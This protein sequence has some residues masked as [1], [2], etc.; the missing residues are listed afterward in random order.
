MK[1]AS[2]LQAFGH[3]QD[4][5]NW[6]FD[7]MVV[8]IGK[9]VNLQEITIPQLLRYISEV[10]DRQSDSPTSWLCHPQL[11]WLITNKI[12]PTKIPSFLRICSSAHT[13]NVSFCLSCFLAFPLFL[14]SA[15]LQPTV[16]PR[17]RLYEVW[18]WRRQLRGNLWLHLHRRLWAAGQRC[19]SVSVRTHLVWH[20]HKLCRYVPHV[21]KHTHIH[22]HNNLLFF[23]LIFQFHCVYWSKTFLMSGCHFFK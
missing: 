17:Q 14:C 12:H 9:L 18:Q 8:L 16:S 1:M 11:T 10:V 6:N 2:V 3:K 7:L 19:Q 15:P 23:K 13:Q 22:K 4:W 21:D 5:A 20:W